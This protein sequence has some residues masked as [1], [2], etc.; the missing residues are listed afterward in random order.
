MVSQKV[1]VVL[2]IVAIVL[3]IASIAVTL[4]TLNTKLVTQEGVVGEAKDTEVGHVGI[5]IEQQ[6]GSD[7]S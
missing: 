7:S 5:I 3:S 4:S 1:I 2:L 6:P